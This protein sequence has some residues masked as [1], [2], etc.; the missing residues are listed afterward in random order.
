MILLHPTYFP[1]IIQMATIAQAEA[2]VFEVEDNY[3]KQ[4]YRNRCYIA[5]TNGK[6][7][8]NVPIKHSKDGSRQKMKDVVVENAFPWQ[9]E[10]WRSIQNAYRTSPFFEFYEDELSPLFTE[11]VGKLL[12]FNL[13]IYETLAELIGLDI[14][15]S[16]SETYETTPQITDKR[17]LANA[18]T[19]RKTTLQP[20]TQVLEA[21]HGWLPNLSVL[22]VLFNEGPN[23]LN[24][25]ESQELKKAL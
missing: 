19:E 1:S 3:Q 23:T 12:D 15:I 10:Q 4:T 7:L 11:P 25:L 20:Y 22:D 14:P 5:H 9:K 17:N 21:Q 2:V 18:K 13:K 16:F 24:Y 8:L 6:L